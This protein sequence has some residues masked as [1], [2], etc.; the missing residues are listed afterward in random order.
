LSHRRQKGQQDDSQDRDPPAHKLLLRLNVA[1]RYL[2]AGFIV[3]AKC[4]VQGCLA[5]LLQMETPEPSL[6]AEF[7]E[8]LLTSSPSQLYECADNSDIC[9]MH[10]GSRLISCPTS[11]GGIR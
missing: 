6:S 9:R 8:Y 11:S 1:V 3:Y 5:R 10:R 7:R 4:V 2:V